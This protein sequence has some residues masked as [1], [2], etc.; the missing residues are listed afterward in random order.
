[1]LNKSYQ[2]MISANVRDSVFLEF[3]YY[4]AGLNVARHIAYRDENGKFYSL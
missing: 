1:M 3:C 2:F 4:W